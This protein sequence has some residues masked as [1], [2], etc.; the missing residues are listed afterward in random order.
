MNRKG[1]TLAE[2][3]GVI[4]ILGL[5]VIVSFPP[6]LNQLK[7][8]KSTLSDATLKVIGAGAEAYVDEHPSTYPIKNGNVYCLKLETLVN[9]GYLKSPILDASTGE[10]INEATNYLKFTITSINNYQYELVTSCTENKQ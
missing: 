3:L 6:L 2:V 9:N 8:S 10:A 1:F 7:K 5:L 4:I